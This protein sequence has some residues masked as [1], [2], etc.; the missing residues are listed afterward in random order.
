MA[1]I[2]GNDVASYQGDINY[3]VYKNNS[4]FIIVKATEG[5]GFVDPKFKRN[6]SEARR[7]N[8]PLGY[9]HFARPDLNANAEAEADHFLATLGQIY[10]GEVLVLDYEPNWAGDAVT[11]CKRWLDRVFLKTNCRPLIYLNQN[12]LR[13]INWKAVSDGGYGLWVASYTY[14]PNNNNFITGSFTFAAMQQWTNRQQVPGI[15]GN[16][17][18]N[19]FF[20]DVATFKRYGYQPA[21]PQPPTTDYKALYEEEKKK[22][23]SLTEALELSRLEIKNL[24][25]KITRAKAELA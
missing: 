15:A 10:A 17:D 9:Y 22:T 21:S 5:V 24:T 12:Q 11:W 23:A 3:D 4:H 2:V 8:L 25:G 19:V 1:R 20:G 6:Q 7:V 18:G 14:D 13:T 16:V